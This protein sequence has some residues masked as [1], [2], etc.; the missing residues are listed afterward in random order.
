MLMLGELP[1]GGEQ[2]L[3]VELVLLRLPSE[4]ILLLSKDRGC[5]E[6]ADKTVLHLTKLSRQGP[7]LQTKK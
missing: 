6:I 4:L 3:C 5:F 1:R 7:N 2:Y